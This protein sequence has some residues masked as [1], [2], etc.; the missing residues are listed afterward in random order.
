LT[1][2]RVKFGWIL[3]GLTWV[4]SCL[5]SVSLTLGW[6]EASSIPLGLTLVG[7]LLGSLLLTPT[8]VGTK[9]VVGQKL[10]AM[11]PQ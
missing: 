11:E 1:F 10:V 4:K 8:H 9:V 5:G 3:I 2:P 7:F 6:V